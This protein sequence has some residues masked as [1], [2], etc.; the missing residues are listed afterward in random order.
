MNGSQRCSTGTGW[1]SDSYDEVLK[2]L[3][4]GN[5]CFDHRETIVAHGSCQKKRML[6]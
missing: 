3:W 6:V 2:D 5:A 4:S 1:I